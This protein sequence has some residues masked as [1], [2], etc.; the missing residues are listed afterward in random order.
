MAQT[1]FYSNYFADTGID[2]NSSGDPA[3]EDRSPSQAIRGELVPF[4]AYITG[5]P[6]TTD[7]WRFIRVPKGAKLA[8]ATWS[9]DDL[10]TTATGDLGWEST[11]SAGDDFLNDNAFG[12]AST[13]TVLTPAAIMAQTATSAAD[14]LSITWSAVTSGASGTVR[15]IGAWFVP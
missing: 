5:T 12:T 2:A 9:N 15:I 3:V 7:T 13:G 14:Y 4:D 1:K 6:A 11:A 10:G 8:F